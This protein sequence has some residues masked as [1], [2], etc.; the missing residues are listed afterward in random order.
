MKVNISEDF[1]T[2]KEAFTV[3]PTPILLVA[4]M[5]IVNGEITLDF[6]TLNRYCV[7]N[8]KG[9]LAQIARA[10]EPY[11][12]NWPDPELLPISDTPRFAARSSTEFL[13]MEICRK[14]AADIVNMTTGEW[15]E[16]AAVNIESVRKY[17]SSNHFSDNY[18]NDIAP[19]IQEFARIL[20]ARK[21]ERN[22]ALSAPTAE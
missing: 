18:V 8:D 20:V 15:L 4:S 14:Q 11:Y 13:D 6:G 21:N 22:G 7:I 5:E 1:I 19:Y 3:K 16:E 2:T 9:S 17:F 12:P 10:D